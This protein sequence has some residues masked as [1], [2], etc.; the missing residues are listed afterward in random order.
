MNNNE[1]TK[2]NEK[3]G[4]NFISKKLFLKL[5]CHKEPIICLS[6]LNDGR[7][8]SGSEDN[9]I[10]IYNKITFEPELTIRE[11]RDCIVSITIINKNILA[12]CSRDKTIKLF[13]IE[14]DKCEI[15][16]T[17]DY[18]KDWVY[19]IIELKNNNLI[20]CSNNRSIIFYYKD[21]N[22]TYQKDYEDS[23]YGSCLSISQVNEKE[24]CYLET[25]D[26]TYHFIRFYDLKEKK[27]KSSI[28]KISC[29]GSLGPFNIVTKNLLIIG[30]KNIL[31][32]IDTN[33]YQLIRS[34][35]IIN[36]GCIYGFC[37]LN[38]N[39]FLTG[40]S[41]GIIR[42]WKIEGDNIKEVCKKDKCHKG[43]IFAIVNIG[44]GLI[45]SCS[46]DQSIKIW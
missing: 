17:L 38:E 34:I 39:E 13:K 26:Y 10:I 40:D 4:F 29:T 43:P 1:L 23:I 6:V 14:Q 19:K 12:S 36:S 37:L 25:R 45:A 44:N 16:Q 24:I 35:N 20:S 7:L 46:Y 18:H 41:K 2:K 5:S 11:H 8:V 33:L 27:I 21:N 30:G 9:N 31:F 3:Y 28:S 22:N 15:F 42:Q 32:M